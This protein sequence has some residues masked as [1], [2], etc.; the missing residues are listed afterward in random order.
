[1]QKNAIF[2]RVK[3]L[4]LQNMNTPSRLK[5]TRMKHSISML[6]REILEFTKQDFHL[7]AYAYTFVFICV[8][9]F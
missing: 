5:D 1:M 3:I 7:S 2:V 8:I 4:Y 9:S 6:Y